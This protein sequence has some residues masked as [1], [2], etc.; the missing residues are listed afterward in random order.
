[1][2][3]QSVLKKH[4]TCIQV[5]DVMT[6]KWHRRSYKIKA[7]L[8]VGAGGSVYLCECESRH[9]ALKISD[10]AS[11]MTLEMNMLKALKEHRVA[12]GPALIDADD[13]VFS[14]EPQYSFYVME[15]IHG[16]SHE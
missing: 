8:R 3:M 9:Y 6:G 13:W 11:Q 14:P 12:G 2:M 15:Y 4:K 10:P 5:G 16:E 1:M 7:N